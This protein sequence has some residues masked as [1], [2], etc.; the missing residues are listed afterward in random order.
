MRVMLHTR[1]SADAWLA[2]PVEVRRA[3]TAEADQRG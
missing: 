1:W 2:V 3:F